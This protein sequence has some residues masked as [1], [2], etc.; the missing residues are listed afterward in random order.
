[1]VVSNQYLAPSLAIC[2]MSPRHILPSLMVFHSALNSS[3]SFRSLRSILWSF[4]INSSLL[5]FDILQKLSFTWIMLPLG[6]VMSTMNDLSSANLYIESSFK[7]SCN[8]RSAFS[9][10]SMALIPFNAKT[11]FLCNS[12]K[13][14][15]FMAVKG[16]CFAR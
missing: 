13:Y 15:H 4:P 16:F 5:Y 7:L 11:R 1:M 10:S 6:S 14:S 3:V 12:F 2:R 9:F 8:S